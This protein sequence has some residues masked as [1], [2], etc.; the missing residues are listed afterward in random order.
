MSSDLKLGSKAPPE[1]PFPPGLT[2]HID[3]LLPYW[4]ELVNLSL[5]VGKMV[6]M[7][8]QVILP[9]IKEVASSTETE[10]Y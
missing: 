9:I 6:K 3:T 5:E 8:S 10:A 1:D 7:K 4:V 2:V